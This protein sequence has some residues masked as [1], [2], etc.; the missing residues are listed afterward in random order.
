M[1]HI[2]KFLKILK[3]VMAT[4][5]TLAHPDYSQ[6]FEIYINVSIGNIG[7]VIVQNGQVIVYFNRKLSETQ[8]KYVVTEL[9]LLSII[10]HPKDF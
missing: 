4:D 5:I 8:M 9:K 2:N 6:P 3:K 10:E 7:A 1:I